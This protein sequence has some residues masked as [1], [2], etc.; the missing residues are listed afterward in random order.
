[1]KSIPLL[2]SL[3]FITCS[4]SAQDSLQQPPKIKTTHLFRDVYGNWYDSK[5][6]VETDIVT[7]KIHKEI[8]VTQWTTIWAADSSYKIE[9][10]LVKNDPP[11]PPPPPV[12]S[13]ALLVRVNH[14]NPAGE[15][16]FYMRHNGKVTQLVLDKKPTSKKK[17]TKKKVANWSGYQGPAKVSRTKRGSTV[18]YSDYTIMVVYDGSYNDL[19]YNRGFLVLQ[20]GKKIRIPVRV[21]IYGDVQ[22]NING[23]WVSF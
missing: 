19:N 9:Y 20:D 8:K 10:R 6:A 11:P 12:D 17:K 13:T 2:L 22:F 1:M 16:S 5:G 4:S 21:S 15:G 3:L 23:K 18:R 14:T 7:G